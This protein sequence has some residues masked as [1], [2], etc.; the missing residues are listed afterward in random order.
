MADISEIDQHILRKIE[1]HEEL[2]LKYEATEEYELCVRERNE[3]ERLRR[4]LSENVRNSL[5]A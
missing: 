4:M 3:I 1:Y 2:R 5:T